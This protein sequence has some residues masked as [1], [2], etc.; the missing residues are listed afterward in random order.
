MSSFDTGYVEA[1]E[2]IFDIIFTEGLDSAIKASKN[3][4]I[5]WINKKDKCDYD[6]GAVEGIMDFL[7][8]H[9]PKWLSDTLGK[10]LDKL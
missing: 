3:A 6:H 2:N 4:I 7:E 1:E 10:N 9:D 8:R 5:A